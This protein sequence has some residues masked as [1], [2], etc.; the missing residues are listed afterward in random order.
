MNKFKTD[1]INIL[2]EQNPSLFEKYEKLY[3]AYVNDES[4]FKSNVH[5]LEQH[6]NTLLISAIE[7]MTINFQIDDIKQRYKEEI[8]LLECELK[9]IN[10]N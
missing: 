6:L 9:D 3:N 4:L 2:Q 7:L 1:L 10:K 8:D 5:T